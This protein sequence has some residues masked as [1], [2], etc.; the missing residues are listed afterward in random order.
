MMNCMPVH[1]ATVI[2]EQCQLQISANGLTDGRHGACMQHLPSEFPMMGEEEDVRLPNRRTSS[3]QP[4][5][6]C[7]P[8]R[9]C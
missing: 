5:P 1:L 3:E 4:E 8:R 7:S 6:N 9:L 2:M